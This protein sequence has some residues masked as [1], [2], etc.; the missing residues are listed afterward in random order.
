MLL[1]LWQFLRGYVIIVVTGFS[2]ERFV[3]LAVHNGV[4]IWDFYQT[5]AGATMKVSVRGFKRLKDFAKRTRCHIKIIEKKGFPFT[6]FRYRKRK[7]LAAGIIFFVFVLYFLSTFVWLIEISGNKRIAR[8]EITSFCNKEGLKLGVFKRKVDVNDLENKFL[9]AFSDIS[10]INIHIKGTKAVIT[11]TE[12][13]EK[14]K[15]IDKSTPCNIIAK[16]DGLIMSIATSAGKP[17]VRQKDVVQKGDILVSGQLSSQTDDGSIVNQ[18]V[19]AT[20]EVFAKMYYEIN[21]T[22][23]LSYTEKQYTGNEKTGFSLIAFNKNFNV[24]NTS[25]LYESYDKITTHKQIRLSE[26]YP[27]PFIILTHKYSEFTPI[28]KKYTIESAKEQAEKMVNGR[29]IREFDFQTD[30]IDKKIEF[31]ETENELIVNAIITTIE[32]IDEQQKLE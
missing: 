16:K 8:E 13:I 29:I 17:L 1:K 10:W 20:A 18:Y 22:L 9:S 15:I 32:R 28:E 14:P 19:H 27:L 6:A 25:I 23:P 3:N 12:I 26:N 5:D 2:V 31:T 30:I 4:Y 11:L 7:I 21:F 24:L